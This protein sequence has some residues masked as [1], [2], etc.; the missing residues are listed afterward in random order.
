MNRHLFT[1]MMALA[2]IASAAGQIVNDPIHPNESAQLTRGAGNS[3]TFSWWKITGRTYFLQQS[4][5]LITWMYFPDVIEPGTNAIRS[6]GFTLSGTNR[7]FLRLRYSDIPTTD[8]AN[9]DFNGDFLGNADDLQIGLAPL[10]LDLDGDGVQNA[11]EYA[12]GTNPFWNDTDGDGVLDGVDAFPTDP[13]RST[14]PPLNP[15]DHTPPEIKIIFP[16]SGIT[17]LN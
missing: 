8:P 5:N 6:Y 9:A 14:A 3:Y 4:T 7:F 16:A 11:A 2:L 13:T 15:G 17:P 1:L 10:E 12:S